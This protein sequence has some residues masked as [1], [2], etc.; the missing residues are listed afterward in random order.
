MAPLAIAEELRKAAIEKLFA[1]NSFVT[2]WRSAW[3]ARVSILLGNSS[4]GAALIGLGDYLSDIFLTTRGEG[5]DGSR[6]SSQ[7]SLSSGGTAWECLTTWYLNLCLAGTRAVAVRMNKALVPQ[8]FLDAISV[9][10]GNIKTNTESDIIIL[11]FPETRTLPPA[12]TTGTLMQR[13]SI[14][15]AN[16]FSEFEVGVVQCKTNWNDNAQ[17]P[18][19]WDMVYAADRFSR[20]LISVGTTEYRISALRRFSYSFVTVPTS[21]GPFSPTS[22]CVLRVKNLS[23]GNYWGKPTINGVAFSIKEIL[24]RNFGS[25]C[26]NFVANAGVTLQKI[27]NKYAYFG[28]Y[29]Q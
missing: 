28:L 29:G 19:L 7:S 4:D 16:L 10:Y 11:V 8:P 17:I 9:S 27:E 21:R 1:T 22:T 13:L 23:G 2:P 14:L 3:S 15:A 5:R 6:E 20:A 18:M 24:N 26:D 25:C 12:A